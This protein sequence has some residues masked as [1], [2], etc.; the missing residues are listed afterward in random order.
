MSG[1]VYILL[2]VHNR[3]ETTRKFIDSLLKQTFQDYHLLLIDDGST[4]GTDE[5][6]RDQIAAEKLTVIRGNGNWWWAGS[7]QQGVNWL[8]IHDAKP[9]DI[10]LMIND[11]VSF[12]PDFLKNGLGYIQKHPN[13]LL[14][15]RFYDAEKGGTVETGVKADF[16]RFSFV[17]A[18]EP[19]EINCLSTRGL[20]LTWNVLRQL[21]NFHPV[22]L[23]HYGSDYEFTMR[24]VKKSLEMKTVPEVFLIPDKSATGVREHQANSFADEIQVMF[25]KRCVYNPVYRTSLILLA[26]P[27]RFMPFNILR[28]WAGAVFQLSKILLK[29]L[30]I[31][32][33]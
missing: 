32:K 7:L 14:L 12:R 5:M 20:F 10:V 21:G 27:V 15:S 16:R 26:L 28:V 23:P 3:K 8:E 30:A 25:S 19:E 6:V 9:S 4:D 2:P 22:M 11:D 17:N 18:D 29:E 24:A 33:I 1:R 31:W 13:I